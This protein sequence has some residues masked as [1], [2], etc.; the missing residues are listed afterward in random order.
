MSPALLFPHSERSRLSK[1]SLTLIHENNIYINMYKLD[2]MLH[3]LLNLD[4]GFASL[5][6]NRRYL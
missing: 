6:I 4:S 3:R 1:K 2:G 5:D